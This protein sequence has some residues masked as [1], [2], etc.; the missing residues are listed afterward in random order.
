[1]GNRTKPMS[2]PPHC[3]F[4]SIYAQQKT[5]QEYWLS[6]DPAFF[7][8]KNS[9]NDN[10]YWSDESRIT[11]I[12]ELNPNWNVFYCFT[13]ASLY[14]PRISENEAN[15]IKDLP[16]LCYGLLDDTNILPPL[17]CPD[18]RIFLKLLSVRCA[19]LSYGFGEKHVRQEKSISF[20]SANDQHSSRLVCSLLCRVN[21]Q[22]LLNPWSCIIRDTSTMHVPVSKYYV[23]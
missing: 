17:R 2:I 14:L 5:S 15:R 8:P 3:V 1:M 9:Q 21:P 4:S 6:S 10:L 18:G 12:F 23:R 13:M 7:L 20:L 19:S 16:S 11:R 22:P